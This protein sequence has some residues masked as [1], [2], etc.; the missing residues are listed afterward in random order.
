MVAHQE[1]KR[2][3]ANAL[4]AIDFSSVSYFFYFVRRGSKSEILFRFK[5]LTAG[6]LCCE[7]KC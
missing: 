5:T 6:A 3:F 1:N 7:V 2:I 4:G